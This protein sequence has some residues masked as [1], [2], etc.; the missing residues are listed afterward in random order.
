MTP[1]MTMGA[2]H[3]DAVVVQHKWE[4]VLMNMT[5]YFLKNWLPHLA[6]GWWTLIEHVEAWK[7]VATDLLAT[8]YGIKWRWKEFKGH[9]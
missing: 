7:E 8:I 4:E 9:Q 1:C 2:L 6:E 5:M 3:D